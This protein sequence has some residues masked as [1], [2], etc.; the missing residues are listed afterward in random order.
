MGDENSVRIR[1][2]AFL[3]AANAGSHLNISE[4]LRGI[5]LGDS[6]MRLLFFCLCC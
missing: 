5:G 2:E 4:G 6:L 1:I 3:S